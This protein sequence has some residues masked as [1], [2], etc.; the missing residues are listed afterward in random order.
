LV[1]GCDESLQPNIFENSPY[2]VQVFMDGCRVALSPTI[3]LQY[4]LQVSLVFDAGKITV[5]LFAGFL[6]SSERSLLE[7]LQHVVYELT[8]MIY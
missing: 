4:A 3:I 7:N 8:G 6:S 1:F 5:L 2:M